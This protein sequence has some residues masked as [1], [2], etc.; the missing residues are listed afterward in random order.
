MQKIEES[1]EKSP[2][3]SSMKGKQ[4]RAR[5]KEKKQ[6][7]FEQ[8]IE[9]GKIL[10]EQKGFYGFGMRSLARALKMSQGNLYNYVSSKRELWIAIRRSYFREFKKGID[11]LI[12]CHMGKNID[13]LMEISEYVIEFAEADRRRWSM[14]NSIPPPPLREDKKGNIEEPGPIEQAYK[15]FNLLDSI[16]MVIK[17]AIHHGEIQPVDD[18]LLTY[19]LYSL[20]IGFVNANREI[21]QREPIYEPI[22]SE[23]STLDGLIFRKFALAMIR[24]QLENFDWKY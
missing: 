4:T 12:I 24:K 3:P 5:S 8:I 2:N 18:K 7:Q 19:Y 15:P 17:K 10:L 14:V 13:L 21:S 16:H 1:S 9:E 11:N 20:S 23:D 6:E 22:L